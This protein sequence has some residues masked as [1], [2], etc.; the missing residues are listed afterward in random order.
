M[1]IGIVGCAGRMGRMLI[2][3]VLASEGCE[4]AGGTEQA[5]S[6]M[7]GQDLGVLSGGET[8]GIVAT[9]SPAELF[10]AADVIIDFTFQFSPTRL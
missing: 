8:V 1:K 10:Q 7:I 2:A 6:E 3:E 9:D 4:L 5:G